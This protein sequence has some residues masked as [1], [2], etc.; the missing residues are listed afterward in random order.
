MKKRR[1]VMIEQQSKTAGKTDR[2]SYLWLAIAIILLLFANGKWIIPIA[3][4]L[5]TVFMIRFLRT[6]KSVRGLLIAFPLVIVVFFVIWR[7]LLPIPGV[8][9]YISTGMMGLSSFLPFIADRIVSPRLKGFW[10]T[11]VFPLT[12]T[13]LEFLSMLIGSGSTWGSIAYTQYGNLPLVQ[14]VSVTGMGGLTFLIAWFA[15]VVNFAW[16]K[17]FSW[18]DIRKG[19]ML[20]A[21]IFILVLL[22][23]GARLS[24]FEPES[25]TVRVSSVTSSTKFLMGEQLVGLNEKTKTSES[26]LEEHNRLFERSMQAVQAGAKIIFWQE[27]SCRVF[28]KDESA[29][30]ERGRDLAR[31]EKIYLGMAMVSFPNGDP[32]KLFENKIIWIDPDGEIITEYLKSRPIPGEGSIPGSGEIPVLETPHG[33]IATAICYDMDFA[34]LINQAGKSDADIMISPSYD[35]REI[36]PLH[37]HMA[38]FRAIE[39][40][41][42]LIRGTGHGLSIAVDYQGRELAKLNWFNSGNMVML[43]DVPTHGV[44]TVFAKTGDLFSWLCLAGLIAVI[45]R[46]LFHRKREK[47]A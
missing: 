31:R 24:L 22:L 41:F 38:V 5:F 35:W 23:G 29:F 7:G 42:S 16:E 27:S 20:Y 32:E 33:R 11:L 47:P 43:A 6:Q 18:E 3:P 21:G 15:S 17:D 46:V 2:L 45:G 30:V 25:K 28:K 26:M 13:S 37:T 44:T 10:A 40:G 4:W 34:N 19:M 9:Y 36:V 39:N 1:F 8:L 14:I 12:F